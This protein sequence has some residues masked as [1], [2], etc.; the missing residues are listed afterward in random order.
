[1]SWFEPIINRITGGSSPQLPNPQISR[2]GGGAAWS[3]RNNPDPSTR[4][5][6]QNTSNRIAAQ[7]RPK[8]G[9]APVDPNG[10]QKWR[11]EI[12]TWVAINGFP[13]PEA[14]PGGAGPAGG[15]GSGYAAPPPLVLPRMQLPAPELLAQQAF[16][17]VDT[18]RA[19][20][21][22]ALAAL[23]A[24]RQ[25]GEQAITAADREATTASART[26]QDWQ[27]RTAG[28]EGN[29]AAVY[30]DALSQLAG[31]VADNNRAMM[32][33]GF[34]PADTGG[35]AALGRLSG[36]GASASEAALVRQRLGADAYRDQRESVRGIT[37]AGREAL[38]STYAQVL[39][40]LQAQQAAAEAAARF[41]Q[42][43]REMAL[44]QQIDQINYY[45]SVQEAVANR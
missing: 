13:G 27:R 12:Q 25:Q 8:R 34:Q 16:M 31:V 36:L 4:Q 17:A 10:L 29:I 24:S 14:D 30:R 33:A 45:A 38:A 20:Y 19:P 18:A 9:P 7:Q 28:I 1:M 5:T 40:G 15:G 35:N 26:Q 11:D 44:R 37:Q 43:N 6:Q 3:I 42:F 32:A 22:A 41:E 21:T 39:G 23:A 2:P